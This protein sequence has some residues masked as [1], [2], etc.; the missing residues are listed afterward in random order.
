[1]LSGQC[2]CGGIEIRVSNPPQRLYRCHCSL[3]QKQSGAGANA[4]FITAEKNLEWIRGETLVTTYRKPTGFGSN[5]CSVCGCPVPNLVR[6]QGLYWIPAGL[7]NDVSSL[8]VAVHLYLEDRPAWDTA[9]LEGTVF[10]T[11]PDLTT[12]LE[13]LHE[14]R[15]V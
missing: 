5:F 12:L 8:E 7:L 2:I 9:P 3:C 11:M 4:A 13:L 14:P 6:N 10:Q 15:A 1:M